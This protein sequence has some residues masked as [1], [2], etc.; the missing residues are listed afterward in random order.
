MN[1]SLSKL[2][3]EVIELIQS[4]IINI[5]K[6]NIYS[7]YNSWNTEVKSQMTEK[8]E[9]IF[10]KKHISDNQHLPSNPYLL[11]IDFPFW[12]GKISSSKKIMV[13]GIDPLRNE[14]VFNSRNAD[15]FNNVLIGTPYALH[16]KEIRNGKTRPYWEFIN[17]L[18]KDN[19][20]YLTDFYKT[21][22]Y[23]NNT[24]TLRSYNY[25]KQDK[26]KIK[27]FREILHREINLINPDVIITLGK[28]SFV[29]LTG[30]KIGN[31][32]K[33]INLSDKFLDGFP[34]IPIIP[35]IHLSSA[36]RKNNIED[37]LKINDIEITNLNKRY[38]Y[39]IEYAKIIERFI[40]K[41]K[42][43]LQN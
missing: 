10:D 38:Q 26:N 21:F 5:S 36:T 28:Q 14:K 22:F 9:W 12:F 31:L 18:S 17:S 3:D 15:K 37:F 4:K 2:Q 23:T 1:L 24:K 40:S 42:D 29:H 8:P 16:S 32:S 13:I 7:L 33:N 39:G 11:G 27:T 20:V 30:Q 19:F 35:M 6:E 25:Y 43:N 41:K 34:N